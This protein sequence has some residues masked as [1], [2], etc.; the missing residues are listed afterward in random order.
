[1]E[2]FFIFLAFL[3]SLSVILV[4]EIGPPSPWF[5]LVW[6]LGFPERP[7]PL[8]FFGAPSSSLGPTFVSFH[9]RK[10]TSE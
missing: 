6:G 1:V 7:F 5:S 2:V 9:W 3:V 4:M 10:I 8:D